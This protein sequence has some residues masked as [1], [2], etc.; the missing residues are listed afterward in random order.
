MVP[1][2]LAL[3]LAFA[4]CYLA[5]ALLALCQSAHRKAVDP[6]ARAPS[7]AGQLVRVFL[8]VIWLASA[9]L[10]LLA[11]QSNGF[12]TLLWTLMIS[13]SAFALAL[14]LSWKPSGLSLLLKVF[15][16]PAS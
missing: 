4:L 3:I 10:V 14:T 15:G 6:L 1:E 2:L 8:A 9:L 11:T 7:P 12:G 13:T 5:F 16:W